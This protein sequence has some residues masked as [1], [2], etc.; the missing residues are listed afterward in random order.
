MWKLLRPYKLH[1]IN[2]TRIFR[3]SIRIF[4]CF[5]NKQPSILT[6]KPAVAD[7]RLYIDDMLEKIIEHFF[8]IFVCLLGRL[9]T[10]ISEMAYLI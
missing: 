9:F 8:F 5:E 6:I 1:L 10:L 2:A 3:I 7:G 4:E